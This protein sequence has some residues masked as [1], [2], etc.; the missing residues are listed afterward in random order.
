MSDQQVCISKSSDYSTRLSGNTIFLRP[1]KDEFPC[2]SISSKVCANL[3]SSSFPARWKHLLPLLKKYS[4]D[5]H[6]A[7]QLASGD[8]NLSNT[9]TTFENTPSLDFIGTGSVNIHGGLEFLLNDEID[10]SMTNM[11]IN[12]GAS[13]VA[14]LQI[15]SKIPAKAKIQLSYINLSGQGNADALKMDISGSSSITL[16]ERFCSHVVEDGC[17]YGVSMTDDSEIHKTSN[18]T[19]FQVNGTKGVFGDVE[20]S[21]HSHLNHSY[22]NQIFKSTVPVERTLIN[23]TAKDF[24]Q[25]STSHNNSSYDL[26]LAETGSLS[27]YTITDNASKISQRWNQ[28][29]E[30][31]RSGGIGTNPLN[32][33]VLQDQGTNKEVLPNMIYSGKPDDVPL[34]AQYSAQAE[35]VNDVTLNGFQFNQG[36]RLIDA[37]HDG[38]STGNYTVQNVLAISWPAVPIGA[39]AGFISFRSYGS[40]PPQCVLNQLNVKNY[41][42]GSILDL[43]GYIIADIASCKLSTSS[44]T[45]ENPIICIDNQTQLTVG[46]SDLEAAGLG[47]VARNNGGAL[48]FNNVRA[49][50]TDEKQSLIVMTGDVP[51]TSNVNGSILQSAGAPVFSADPYHRGFI[52]AAASS[53]VGMT[54]GTPAIDAKGVQVVAGG[55]LT[56][57]PEDSAKINVASLN[58]L[59]NQFIAA[60]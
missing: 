48:T 42:Y 49:K 34:Y 21:G 41:P 51:T 2:N 25:Y 45:I 9:N 15:I 26:Q 43:D 37:Q 12:S 27:S 32:M 22:S 40:K 11:S 29:F 54:L 17:A 20:L 5:Q 59:P 16:I 24:A 13:A 23:F 44:S 57:D 50:I 38:T 19:T 31:S 10:V 46:D 7:I 58:T 36:V 28:T 8:Y 56:I 60:K 47:G 55:N 39:A 3:G 53:F 18:D 14:A 33:V 52:S 6:V 35:S 4:P 1:D 30:I